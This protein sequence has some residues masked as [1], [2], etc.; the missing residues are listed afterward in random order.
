MDLGPMHFLLGPSIRSRR[1]EPQGAGTWLCEIATLTLS[2]TSLPLHPQWYDPPSPRLAFPECF[3]AE[4]GAHPRRKSGNPVCAQALWG[5]F[6]NAQAWPFL[7]RFTGPQSGCCWRSYCLSASCSGLLH[8]LD[9]W[10]VLFPFFCALGVPWWPF[11]GLSNTH[12]SWD[13]RGLV[14]MGGTLYE[15]HLCHLPW[16]PLD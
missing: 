2:G 10:Q 16:R 8:C 4:G 9:T 3:M 14:I 13:D 12:G 7:F 15:V 6:V 5:N 11:G 1:T